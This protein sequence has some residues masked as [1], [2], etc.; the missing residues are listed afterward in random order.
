MSD[1]GKVPLPNLL[2]AGAKI[3]NICSV[4]RRELTARVS[5]RVTSGL[6]C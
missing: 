3:T 6:V 5:G 4:F 2:K 1:D